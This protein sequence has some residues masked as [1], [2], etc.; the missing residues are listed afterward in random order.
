MTP[1]AR[2]L[3][4]TT[5]LTALGGA[6]ALAQGHGGFTAAQATAGHSVYAA[7]CAGCHRANLVGGGDA[8]ALGG[9]GGDPAGAGRCRIAL[10]K[11]GGVQVMLVMPN[12]KGRWWD[13]IGIIENA[14]DAATTH[15]A[16]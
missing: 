6:Y 10:A 13:A 8:P 7:S 15:A 14:F 11:K 16:Q 9:K 2:I 4:G 1:R 5:A 12:A 3:A